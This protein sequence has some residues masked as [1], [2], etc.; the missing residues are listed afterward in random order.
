MA[1]NSTI[2]VDK[3][4]QTGELERRGRA[5]LDFIKDSYNFG[6]VIFFSSWTLSYVYL[7]RNE[8]RLIPYFRGK[9]PIYILSF[10]IGWI[11]YKLFVGYA[12]NISI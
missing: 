4:F 6:V 3:Q 5:T 1:T 11:T 7:R 12:N 10:G 2:L 8:S 9:S